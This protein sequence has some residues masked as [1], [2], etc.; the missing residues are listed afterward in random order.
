[1]QSE[2]QKGLKHRA[3]AS[4]SSGIRACKTQH[5]VLT[6]QEALWS[7]LFR[8][9]TEVS[10][11]KYDQLDNWLYDGTQYPAPPF[12]EVQGTSPGS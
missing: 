8:V 11:H 12:L 7:P 1:M 6:N 5:T 4:S 10:L 3:A 2:V 9:C